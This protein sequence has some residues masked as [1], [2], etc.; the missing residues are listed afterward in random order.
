[1]MSRTRVSLAAALL[2]VLALS[3]AGCGDDEPDGSSDADWPRTTTPVD[4]D[5]LV[6]AAGSTVHLPDGS[7]LDTEDPAGSYVVAGDG[8]WFTSATPGDLEGPAPAAAARHDRR[9]RGA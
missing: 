9:G 7:T 4:A 6:W 8:V 2:G 1:M 5:G 3:A